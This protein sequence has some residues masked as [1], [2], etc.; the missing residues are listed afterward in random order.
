LEVI[1]GE[2]Q[3]GEIELPFEG[4]RMEA[5]KLGFQ[6]TNVNEK[7]Y[8]DGIQAFGKFNLEDPSGNFSG[9]IF[10]TKAFI[11]DQ[12]FNKI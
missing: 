12:K 11:C 4:S 10:N 5:F 1:Y 6:G 8:K 2:N 9:Y 3:A 7:H